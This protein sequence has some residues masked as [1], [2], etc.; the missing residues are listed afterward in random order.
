[1]AD[2]RR[3]VLITGATGFI[4]R[5]V[6]ASFVKRG[7]DVTCLIRSTSRP[8]NLPKKATQ[9]FVNARHVT[10]DDWTVLADLPGP[11]DLILHLSAA[12]TNPLDRDQ[13]V[14][15]NANSIA[16]CHVIRAAHR[17]GAS[18]ISAGSCAEYADPEGA[19]V[20]NET[21]PLQ[22][23]RLY[24]ATKAA[25]TI[26]GSALAASLGVSLIVLRLFGVYG[27]GEAEHRLFPT[28]MHRLSAGQPV[29]LSDGVQV[30]DM[31][32]V[33]EVVSA[34]IAAADNF[35]SQEEINQLVLNVCSGRPVS[36]KMFAEQVCKCLGADT[37]LLCFGAISQRPDDIPV[38]TGDPAE[39]ARILGWRP[40]YGAEYSIKLAVEEFQNG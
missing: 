18:V 12:G 15:I 29:Q 33:A 10:L 38:L 32:W 13:E 6:V 3:R 39:T 5:H 2:A 28:L 9:A 4:G 16:I 34:I 35:R 30:R 17:W 40:A 7:D 14:L 21:A 8:P 19:M 36:V 26:L 24:G 27:I 31:L 37:K 1:M 11:F 23:R 25:G 20:L 22:H